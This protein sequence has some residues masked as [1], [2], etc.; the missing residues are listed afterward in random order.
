MQETVRLTVTGLV[1]EIAASAVGMVLG[2]VLDRTVKPLVKIMAVQV[3][4]I[5]GLVGLAAD[6]E[7]N[8]VLDLG[9][10]VV[11]MQTAGMMLRMVVE[12]KV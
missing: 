2:M 9:I 6:T 5:K 7:M 10:R 1:A 8:P 4:V 3:L 12:E 11:V